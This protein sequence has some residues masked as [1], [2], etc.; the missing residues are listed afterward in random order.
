MVKNSAL[1]LVR[2]YQ[3]AWTSKDF[4]TAARH[5]ADDV[6]FHSPQQHL[7]GATAFMAMLSAFAERI[8]PRW[9]EVA[10]TE[11]GDEVVILYHLFTLTGSP[12]TC[13]DHFTVRDGRIRSETLVFDPKPF[14]ATPQAA[15]TA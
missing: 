10:A 7:S 4:E 15:M 11:A 1:S 8:A 3:G 5:I 6:V 9:E 14:L 2:A 12:A 13:A